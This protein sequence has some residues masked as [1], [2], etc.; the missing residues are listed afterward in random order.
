MGCHGSRIRCVDF[1][2]CIHGVHLVLGSRH[3]SGVDGE[4]G[5]KGKEC[6][7][8][9]EGR[10]KAPVVRH[11]A[12]DGR[13]DRAADGG[14]SERH[15]S[16]FGV[17]TQPTNTHGEDGGEY[18]GFKK[19]QQ[20]DHGNASIAFHTNRQCGCDDD[21]GK[22]EQQY[23]SRLDQQPGQCRQKPADG[24]QGVA[25]GLVIERPNVRTGMPVSKISMNDRFNLLWLDGGDVAL[26]I[27]RGGF[28]TAN[29]AEIREDTQCKCD[30]Y[31]LD[32]AY[33][34]RI[35]FNLFQCKIF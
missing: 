30:I 22:E 2:T 23:P 26:E 1:L 10:A 33:L 28:L 7:H 11:W 24:K 5:P 13:D 21:S 27:S 32:P 6:H 12:H 9:R 29:V 16:E 34:L 20:H 25:D 8:D 3:K 15:C 31:H 35:D 17:C 4:D 14:C 19:L 18:A